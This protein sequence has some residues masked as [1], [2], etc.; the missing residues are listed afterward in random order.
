MT[1]TTKKYADVECELE[2]FTIL[3]EAHVDGFKCGLIWYLGADLSDRVKWLGYGEKLAAEWDKGYRAG[4]LVNI[5]S[6]GGN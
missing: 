6:Q 4:Y 1:T 3:K 2:Q 5:Q